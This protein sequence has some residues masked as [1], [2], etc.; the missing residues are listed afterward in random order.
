MG[1]DDYDCE[2]EK[3]VGEFEKTKAGVKGLVDSGIKKVPRFFINTSDKLPNGNY[4]KDGLKV[5]IPV[6]DFQGIIDEIR[7]ASE[8]WG[9]FQMV[10]HGVPMCVLDAILEITQRFHEQPTE[11]KMEL[12]SSDSWCNVRFYTL[13]GHLSKP[14][15]AN[16][17]DA[18]SCRFVDDVVDPG[19]IPPVCR[20]EI[21]EYTKNMI[22][23]RNVLSELFS[24]ALGLSP[25][26]LEKI[27]CM[28]GEYLSCLYY[29]PCPEPDLTFGT[30]K[31]ND[32]TI[33]T[34]LGQD[35][36]GGLQ[37]HHNNW[38]DVP[39][40]PGALLADIGD[41]LQL[42][43]NDKFKSVEHRVLAR[44]TGTQVSVACF[45]YPSTQQMVKAYGPIKELLSE[46]NPA[47]YREVNY[48]EFVPHY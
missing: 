28:K 42:I 3:E 29:P 14:D 35:R 30:V 44:S 36:S 12:Y 8:T 2:W 38:V 24:E 34:I 25:D 47:L 20:D 37:A 19:V 39:P 23:M 27:Q 22:N 6:I 43:T 16:W 46:D 13:Y 11:A 40:I 18:F 15:V 41:L 21:I 7:R 5:E 1:T 48:I 33:L 45:F 17:R 26:F 9:F 31:R 10:N 32:P 4:T